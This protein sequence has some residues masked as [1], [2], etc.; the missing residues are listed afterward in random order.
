MVPNMLLLIIFPMLNLQKQTRQASEKQD[1]MLQETAHCLC[2]L[3]FMTC[4]LLLIKWPGIL[5][6][7]QGKYLILDY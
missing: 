2:Y 4:L 5:S 6:F 1:T 7:I 3:Q